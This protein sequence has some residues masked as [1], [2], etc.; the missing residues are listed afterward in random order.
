M[1]KVAV[2]VSEDFVKEFPSEKHLKLCLALN[3]D[4]SGGINE[5]DSHFL[6]S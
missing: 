3:G 6:I 4:A 5:N 1:L 2:L